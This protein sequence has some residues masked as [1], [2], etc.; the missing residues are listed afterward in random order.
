MIEGLQFEITTDEVKAKI[1][2]LIEYRKGRIV[3]IEREVKR[4]MTRSLDEFSEKID[5]HMKEDHG[6]ES[7]QV[8]PE[9]GHRPDA[10]RFRDSVVNRLEAAVLGHR[11]AITRLE[12]MRD[13]LVKNETFRLGWME[14]GHLFPDSRDHGGFPTCF[15][16]DHDDYHED[17]LDYFGPPSHGGES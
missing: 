1:E 16:H 5:Q 11:S 6:Q 7:F 9:G 14:L 8:T 10:K 13:H 12:F 17:G 2:A 3:V 4:A 15:G